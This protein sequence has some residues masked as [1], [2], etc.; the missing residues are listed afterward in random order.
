MRGDREMLELILDVARRDERIRAVILNGSRANPNAK[1]DI[2]QD[3]DIVYF[4][5][6]LETF[7]QNQAWIDVF[8]ERL[9]LQMPDEMNLPDYET[10]S[11]RAGFAYLIRFK[12]GNRIDLTLF[13]LDKLKTHF[14][15]DSLSVLLL[16][17]DS[18]FPKLPPPNE[19]NYLIRKPTEK[20]FAD[21]C[22][23]F[24]WV[25]TYVAKGLW[26]KET[27]YAKDFLENPVRKMFLK[28]LEWQIGIENN[29]SVNFGASGKYLPRYV[30]AAFYEKILLTYADAK[31]ENIWKSLFL[32]AEIFEESAKTVAARLEFTY[33]TEESENVIKY[34]EVVKNKGETDLTVSQI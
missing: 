34:L 13:P 25:S 27:L 1:K 15:F 19:K 24:W 14:V 6:N 17:K 5:C 20:E 3:Y 11:E 33:D 16:D 30:S 28:M 23:E 21:V 9:I 10:D 18:I 26:R 29:F 4:V 32:M 22:N 7:T 2:F 12:D 31:P 8:G